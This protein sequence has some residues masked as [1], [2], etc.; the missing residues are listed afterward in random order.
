[1]PTKTYQQYHDLKVWQEAL[2][3]ASE[4]Y[5]IA[6]K[7][8][9]TE[10]YGLTYQLKSSALSIP[11]KIA[12]GHSKR[13]KFDYYLR[14]ALD[15]VYQLENCLR[16]SQDLEYLTETQVKDML[17]KSNGITKMLYGVIKKLKEAK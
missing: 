17:T 15:A 16:L 5:K 12:L 4:V 6:N 9:E 10:I 14:L 8:P 2:Q 1:M 13:Q 11:V 7:L 3:L